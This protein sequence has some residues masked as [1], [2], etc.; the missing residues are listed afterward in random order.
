MENEKKMKY[1]VP[2]VIGFEWMQSIGTCSSGSADGYNCSADGNSAGSSCSGHGMV[3][4]GG[5][6]LAGLGDTAAGCSI[7]FDAA[8]FN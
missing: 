4:D 8:T 3:P 1:E 7:G 2:E 6:N 5:C